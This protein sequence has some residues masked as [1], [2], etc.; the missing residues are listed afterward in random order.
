MI[1]SGCGVRPESDSLYRWR[2]IH[3]AADSIVFAL[4]DGFVNSVPDSLLW[5]LLDSLK[6]TTVERDAENQHRSRV[7]FWKARIANRRNIT[8]RDSVIRDLTD[9]LSLCDTA[10]YEYDCSRIRYLLAL[11]AEYDPLV[12]FRSLKKL[13]RYYYS[14]GDDMMTASVRVDIGHIMGEIGYY[15]RALQYYREADSIYRR[16]GIEPYVRKN[17]LNMANALVAMGDKNAALAIVDSLMNDKS[18]S[19]SPSFHTNL[20]RVAYMASDNADYLYEAERYIDSINPRSLDRLPVEFYLSRYCAD[21]D[22]SAGM[23]THTQRMEECFD[24]AAHGFY[25]PEMLKIMALTHDIYGGRDTALSLYRQYIAANDSARLVERVKEIA[26]AEARSS[27]LKYESEMRHA[28]KIKSL[29]L[30]IIILLLLI[31]ILAV[32]CI[33]IYRQRQHRLTIVRYDTELAH[34]RR[35]VVAQELAMT[36]KDNVLQEVLDNL[37]SLKDKGII[38]DNI[39]HELENSIKLHLSGRQNWDYFITVFNKVCPAFVN[40]LM[41]N[42]PALTE[43]DVRLAVYIRAGLTSKQIAQMLLLQPDSVKKNRQRLRRRM[44]LT[45]SESLEELLYSISPT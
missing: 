32:V 21:T 29:R 30:W 2:R 41:L 11:V 25:Y 39:C 31:L 44:N 3:P 36:E 1:I 20:L 13:D 28:H 14:S 24:S 7:L 37:D 40:T 15:D 18:L 33:Y 19:L 43:G 42:H 9:A 6:N 5:P 22:D 23:R 10:T 12:R 8:G 16:I 38:S 17:T 27:I 35:R 26:N 45:S 34:N 4:E